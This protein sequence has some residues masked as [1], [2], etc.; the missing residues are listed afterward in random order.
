MNNL[1]R[2]SLV[3]F[4]VLLTAC[5]TLQ[6]TGEHMLAGL[7][8]PHISVQNLRIGKSTLKEQKFLVT[9]RIDNPNAQAIKANAVDLALAINGKGIAHGTTTSPIDIKAHD[10]SPLEM[11]V[12]A[13]TF[14]LLEQGMVLSSMGTQEIPYQ[15]TG[16]V[17]LMSGLLQW[18]KLPITYSGSI[19]AAELLK[20]R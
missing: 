20:H 16:H 6:A 3:F 1:S 13:N 5:N 10:T 8:E 4:L 15:I 17:S 12:V 11:A 2:F 14:E 19:N 18:I 7:K 9:L